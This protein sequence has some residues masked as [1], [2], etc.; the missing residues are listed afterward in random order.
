MQQKISLKL[1]PSEAANESI[2][3]SYLAANLS[4][5]ENKITGFYKLK[6]SID[7]RSRHQIWINL[8]LNVF[9]DEP[10]YE[11]VVDQIELQEVN[12]F[13]KSVIIIGAGPAGLFAALQLIELG[14]KPI[15]LERG[16]DVR[17]RRKA[18]LLMRI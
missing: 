17:S 1:T 18:E 11:R 13:S 8:T 4:L 5:T 14:I 9:I 3:K 10:F 7:A 2:I 15:I 12:Q 6:E 16:K